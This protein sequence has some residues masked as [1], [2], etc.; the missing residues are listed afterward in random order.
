VRRDPHELREVIMTGINFA[1][2]DIVRDDREYDSW[3]DTLTEAST[4]LD[5]LQT[6][7]TEVRDL[8]E[9]GGV[10]SEEILEVLERHG[11]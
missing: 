5:V 4:R 9:S 1:V 10:S 7:V 6:T 2:V 8:C 11:V 3:I